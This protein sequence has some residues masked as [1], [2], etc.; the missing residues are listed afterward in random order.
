AESTTRDLQLRE[1]IETMQVEQKLNARI[2][3]VMPY[4]LLIMMVTS[5]PIIRDFYQEPIG[6]IVILFGTAILV[7]GMLIIQKLG[8][9][10]LEQRVFTTSVSDGDTPVENPLENVAQGSFS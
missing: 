4:L 9:I 5:S 1:H 7:A 2:V 10:P 8:K 6:V 3:F